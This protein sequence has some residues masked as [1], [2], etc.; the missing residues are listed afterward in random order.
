[1]AQGIGATLD[2][3]DLLYQNDIFK[4]KRMDKYVY[5]QAWIPAETKAR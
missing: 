3:V 5:S 4:A 2:E 1:V